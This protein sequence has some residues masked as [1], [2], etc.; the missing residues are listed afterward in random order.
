[1]LFI[2]NVSSAQ[3]IFKNKNVAIS[4]S[5]AVVSLGVGIT[6]IIIH[7]HNP[8][9]SYGLLGASGATL[10]VAIVMPTGKQNR[11]KSYKF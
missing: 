7:K 6:S 2:Y 9:L 1:M 10:I 8:K 3:Q 5:F 11:C 4:S